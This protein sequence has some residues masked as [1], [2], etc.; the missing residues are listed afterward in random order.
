MQKD[1]KISL[2]TEIFTLLHCDFQGAES[3]HA[4][5]ILHKKRLL[6]NCFHNPS[7]NNICR[8][9]KVVTKTLDTILNM[10]MLS[11]FGF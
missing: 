2:N 3:F 4:E 9:L 11:F 1:K 10:K 8:H 6:I 7:K 5:I